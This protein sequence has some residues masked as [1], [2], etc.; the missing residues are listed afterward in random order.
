MAPRTAA[1]PQTIQ[2]ENIGDVEEGYTPEA[3]GQVDELGL[4]PEDRAVF[5]GMRDADR[6]LPQEPEEGEGEGEGAPGAGEPRPVLDAPPAPGPGKKQ[7]PIEEE[8]DEP[9]QITRDPRTGREQRTI[10]FG[11]H[12]RLMNK[13]R[14][15]VE[16]L[17]SQAEEGRIS[18]AKLAERLSILND[19]L[20]APPPPRQLTPQEM[21]YQ[22][23]QEALQNPM[24]EDTVDP[25]V[26]LA[27]SIAQM[28]RRQIF[29]ANASMQ[30]QED[31]QQQLTYQS[32]LRDYMRDSEAYSRTEEGQNFFGDNGAYQF[33][34]NSRLV[35]LSFSL[36]DK[37]PRDPN[38][39]FTQ[40]EIDQIIAEF[41]AEERQLVS[42]ALQ[43]RRS[44]ARTVMRYARARGW[45]PPQPAQQPVPP[46]ARPQAPQPGRSQ[47][48]S[49]LAPAQATG[50]SAVAQIQAENA[51]ATASRSLSD[52]GGSPPSEPLSIEQL[53]RMDDNEFGI[54]IDN[55][56]KARL[57]SIMGRD[58]FP[59][60]G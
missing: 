34:K 28:Q 60:R 53:L 24:L 1:A 8:P 25:S 59:G 58:N 50:R 43:N 16:A 10:S 44:P 22:R 20:T 4:T 48:R 18:Q 33:L 55:L 2:P 36:F 14:A 38:E 37:D 9:D 7:A 56:P 39:R 23:Q 32:M 31:T 6:G 54:Y 21:H 11:K 5:D 26:D 52:G 27:A 42:D 35:E 41:N 13:A 3:E 12:Q 47:A 17:R 49:P 57:D 46:G 30:Q 29:L 15:D 51:G 19:A 45:Q 40:P